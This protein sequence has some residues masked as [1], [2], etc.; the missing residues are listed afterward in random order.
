MSFKRN[1]VGAICIAMA[2]IGAAPAEAATCFWVTGTTWNNSANWSSS[3]V[4]GTGGSCAATSGIPKNA[5][6]VANLATAAPAATTLSLDIDLSIATI[7]CNSLTGS[8]GFTANGHNV[9]LS[10]AL[11]CNGGGTRSFTYSTGVW[12]FTG[13]G[14]N[15]VDFSTIS[16]L[17]LT[18]TG[19]TLNFQPAGGTTTPTAVLGAGQSYNVVNVGPTTTGGAIQFTSST[20]T[21]KTFGVT[22]PSNVA[23]LG[24]G[25][26]TIT[27]AVN[28]AGTS[29]NP[30]LVSTTNSGGAQATIHLSAAGTATWVSFNRV[31]LTTNTLTATNCVNFGASGTLSCA[32]P[33]AGGGFIIGGG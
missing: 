25:T 6:D 4:G 22:A 13:T 15:V 27:D 18:T 3:D 19:S 12:T 32:A 14:G 8:S 7:S 2:V 11:T 16:G 23:F 1:L 33:S 24:G 17:T 20:T 9:T 26:T 5:G 10:T 28:W 31:V 30:I 21:I 29:S